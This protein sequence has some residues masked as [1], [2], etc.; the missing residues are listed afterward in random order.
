MGMG[1][2]K[3][4]FRTI[5][6][7]TA[8]FNAPTEYLPKKKVDLEKIFVPSRIQDWSKLNFYLLLENLEQKFKK[9]LS[10][11]R[12]KISF[13]PSEFK[14]LWLHRTL[15]VFYGETVKNFPRQLI[16]FVRL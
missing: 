6:L 8:Y 4:G 7:D 14:I 10:G 1:R 9:I 5:P 3:A 13:S 2:F 12:L 16:P 15:H 11:H